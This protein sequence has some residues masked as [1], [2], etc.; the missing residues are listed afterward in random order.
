[1]PASMRLD[2]YLS[3]QHAGCSRSQA[4]MLCRQGRVSVNGVPVK[5]PAAQISAE[6]DTVTLDGAEVSFV[7]HLYI[8]LNKPAGVVCA[9][10]DRLDPTVLSL[11]PAPLQGAACFRRDGSTRTAR[12]LC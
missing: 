6:S 4:G 9:T 5:N 10:K 11:L 1:M 8:M 2:K 7:E 12:A 3:G